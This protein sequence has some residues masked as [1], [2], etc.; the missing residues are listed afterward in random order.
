VSS[1]EERK[2]SQTAP[3]AREQLTGEALERRLEEMLDIETLGI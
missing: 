3:A 1:Q 2:M